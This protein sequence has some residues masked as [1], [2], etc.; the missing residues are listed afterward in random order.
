MADI[1]TELRDA[2]A[3]K[4]L[5]RVYYDLIPRLIK[6]HEDGLIPV[7]PCKAGDA[8]Y[9]FWADD[10]KPEIEVE[11]IFEFCIDE[12][13]LYISTDPYDGFLCYVSELGKK[14]EAGRVVFLSREAAEAALKGSKSIENS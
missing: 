14:S 2:M 1:F 10:E 4:Q 9:Y 11:H 13:G 6:M 7:L 5:A 3:D 8:V 12:K